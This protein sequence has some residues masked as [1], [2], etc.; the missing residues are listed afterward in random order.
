M[1]AEEAEILAQIAHY[2]GAINRHQ[3]K[4]ANATRPAPYRR[5]TT[6]RHA[7]STRNKT[8][9]LNRSSTPDG[10]HTPEWISSRTNGHMSLTS[11]AAYEA[12]L[13][14]KLE[15]AE[16]A[17]RAKRQAK[18]LAREAK[19][20][21]HLKYLSQT[22]L[23]HEGL[24]YRINRKANL[25]IRLDLSN[26]DTKPTPVS[27][28][29]SGIEFLKSPKSNNLYRKSTVLLNSKKTSKSKSSKFCKYFTQTGTCKN[30]KSCRYQHSID[31]LAICPFYLT[32]R[33]CTKGSSC[34][35]SHTPTPH[36]T[37]VC[38]HFLR[39]ACSKPDCKYSHF[40]SDQD[41][42]I[43]TAFARDGYCDLG[44][45]CVKRHVRE[46]PKFSNTG[47]CDTKGCRLPHIDR[48]STRKSKVLPKPESSDE[49]SDSTDEYEE[50]AFDDSA[51]AADYVK[52]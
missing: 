32:S 36:N 49:S 16:Q 40:N 7:H 14:A 1:S 45:D 2:A 17:R 4:L 38:T 30:A 24:K 31:H 42:P 48:A 26:I 29:V 33:G 37:P 12:K 11:A 22:T 51:F 6:T 23:E 35:L 47:V 34:N 25:L 18:L 43:C 20:A 52:L 8:L 50:E 28:T 15:R 9:V 19:E 44:S 13:A 27:T 5:N 41:A 10:A 3:N 21:E 46:C 39:G